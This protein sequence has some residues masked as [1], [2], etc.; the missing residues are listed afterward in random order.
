MLLSRVCLLAALPGCFLLHHDDD[1][2]PAPDPC[3]FAAGANTMIVFSDLQGV[4]DAVADAQV[5]LI[6]AP[7]GGH[8]LLVG[9][10]V[11]TT[12]KVG[13]LCQLQINA[14]LRD[15]RN[16]RVVGL[17]ERPMTVRAEADGWAVPT[18]GDSISN[19]ANVA[20]CPTSAASVSVDGNPFS[21]EVR[22][23]QAGAVIAQ[24]SVSIVPACATGDSYCHSECAP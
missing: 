20:V 15:P 5:P 6:G 12:D 14:A 18:H 2:A 4:H 10:R 3:T 8:I 22:L 11:Q 9:A 24:T 13:N 1:D 17:E 23:S 7:Q 16:N 21:L 19:L